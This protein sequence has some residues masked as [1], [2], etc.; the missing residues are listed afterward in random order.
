MFVLE[1]IKTLF[2]SSITESSKFSIDSL[3]SPNV[4]LSTSGNRLYLLQISVISIVIS[5]VSSIKFL[6]YE[7]LSNTLR[8]SFKGSL[9]FFGYFSISN[10]TYPV[11]L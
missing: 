5:I 6:S 8:V 11:M 7:K 9:I 3:R 4:W 10:S 1:G 2:K